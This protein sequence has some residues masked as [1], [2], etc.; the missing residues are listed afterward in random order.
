MPYLKRWLGLWWPDYAELGED[1]LKGAIRIA[2]ARTAKWLKS[3]PGGWPPADWCHGSM[4]RI[5]FEERNR[6]RPLLPPRSTSDI[7]LCSAC[8]TTM[9]LGTSHRLPIHGG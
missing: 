8:A 2:Q 7:A 6:G 5:Q 4:T 9:R 3:D 1:L